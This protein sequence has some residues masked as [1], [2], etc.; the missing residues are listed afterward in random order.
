MP[1]SQPTPPPVPPALDF[2]FYAS[3]LNFGFPPKQ[4]VLVAPRFD[5]SDPGSTPSHLSQNS[6]Y[7]PFNPGAMPGFDF[8]SMAPAATQPPP[9]PPPAQQSL[10]ES[11]LGSPGVD[12][13]ILGPEEITNPLGALSNMAGLV[14]AAVERAREEESPGD[15]PLKRLRFEPIEATPPLGPTITE[16]QHLPPVGPKRRRGKKL[17]IH[18]YPDA[19][20]EGYVSEQEGRDLMRMS[21]FDANEGS[22][23]ILLGIIELCALL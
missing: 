18:A 14:E 10:P 6:P 2:N 8:M 13:D 22:R 17:H 11:R 23:Q 9:P 20:T 7:V 3:G 1:P 4:E 12:Q 15:R 16:T 21:V 19:V 5:G